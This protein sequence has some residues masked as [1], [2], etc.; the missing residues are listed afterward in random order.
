MTRFDKVISLLAR[1]AR[2]HSHRVRRPVRPAACR[3]AVRRRRLPVRSAVSQAARGGRPPGAALA[4]HIQPME[5][6]T[7]M[8]RGDGAGR[9]CPSVRPAHPARLYW[10]KSCLSAGGASEQLLGE[11]AAVAGAAQR[12]VTD[13]GGAGQRC[14]PVGL[15]QAAPGSERRP[16]PPRPARPGRRRPRHQRHRDSHP[17]PT[18]AAPFTQSTSS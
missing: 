6:D 9:R 8:C 11:P 3:P 4:P 18:L 16:P 12:A 13:Y 7:R 10:C 15:Q 14:R 5:S 1:A 2:P 17:A